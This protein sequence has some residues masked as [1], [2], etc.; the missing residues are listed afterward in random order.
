MTWQPGD[1]VSLDTSRFTIR[2]VEREDVTETFLNWLTDD[3]V[4]I[5]MNTP[6]RQMS[7][8]QGIR[9]ILSYDN[10]KR[11]FLM[12]IDKESQTAIGFFTLTL[13]PHNV[14]E[15]AVVVGDRD[16]WGQNVVMESRSAILDFAFDTLGVHKIIGRPHGRNFASIFNYNAMGFTCEAVLRQQMKAAKQ[17]ER[18]DQLVYGIFADE[19]RNRQ[20]AIDV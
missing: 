11:F 1:L 20:E 19:W 9:W 17:D 12:V 5:G 6:Q 8:A 3:D 16:F 4:V 15:T 10:E 13:D 18:L 7:V 2:S 14:A